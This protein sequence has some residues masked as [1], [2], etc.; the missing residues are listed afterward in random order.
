MRFTDYLTLVESE[1]PQSIPLL[2]M[3]HPGSA[4]GSADMNL[5]KSQASAERAGLI[6]DLNAWKGHLLIVDGELS[7]EIPRYPQFD[8]AIIAAL[9]AAKQ[10]GHASGRIF[11]CDNLTPS[12][13]GKVAKAVS[14]LKLEPQNR[15]VLTG[16]WY[17]TDNSGAGC[18]NATERALRKAGFQN[19]QISDNVVHDGDVDE[20]PEAY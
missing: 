17:F 10:A 15:I 8:T 1:Q 12:W 20:D 16:A 9:N 6:N 3:V 7:D 18:V 4:C 14:K 11:A 19:I 13:P 2:V 5:G